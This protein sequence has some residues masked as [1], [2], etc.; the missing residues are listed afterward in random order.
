MA[1]S[2]I[3]SV[4]I[5][6]NS[7]DAVKAFQKATSKAA[8]FGSFMGGAA[9][10]GVT[11][12]WDKVSSFGSA[13]MNMSDSTD[14]FVSTMNFAGIDTSNV[15]KASKAARDYADR[16]VYDLSTIQNTTAQ[17]AAN[18]IG[19]Y[20]GLTEAAGNLNAV[21]GGNADTF[22]SVA[23][24]LT[25]TAGAGKLTTENWNQMADAIPGA[26]GKLQKAMKANGAYTGNFRDAMEK[27]EISAAEF[28]Q[29]I[30]Q[31]GMSDVAKEAASSTKTMEGA[32]GN[33]EAAITGGLTDAFD[34]IKPAVTGALTEA[35]NQISQFSQNATN[36]LQQFIQGISDTGALQAFSDMVS[37]IGNALSALGGAF[38]SIATT[39]APGLQGLSDAGGIGTTVGEAFNDAAGIIQ[40]LADKLTQFG[41][42]VSANAEPISGALIAIGGGFA[43]FKVAGV[44]SAVVSALQGFN[45][46]AEAAS[47]G[48]W[49][50]NAA[51]NANPIMIVVTA[52]GALVSALA[53]FFTQTETG[54]QI[55]S[56]FT[57]F[58]G[59]CVNNIIAFFQSLPGR[60]GAFFQS[61]A[62]GA[63]NTW[64]SVVDWFKGLPGRIL[65]AIGN[66]GNLLADAGKSIIDGFLKGLKSAWNKVTGWIGG[67]GD[68]I[69]AH[70]GPISYDRRLLVP[71][72]NAI[73]TGFAQGLQSGF[74]ST[75]RGTIGTVNRR[76]ASTSLAIGMAGVSGSTVVNKYEITVSG[77]VT[78]PD[79]TAKQIIRLIER[80]EKSRR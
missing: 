61:A 9:L 34:L 63:R 39:I 77:I 46:A 29:A 32:L 41:D 3:M 43:A 13:V 5:T 80:R 42:W 59:N 50:L 72:G 26:S 74:D 76:L 70:K 45:L 64:N 28:N 11:A 20:T 19:D 60:I 17:L 69:K 78:D 2:A 12:L 75:V 55:W 37:S 21:A 47:I 6:G 35:G 16:T 53:W 52:I 38:A 8:A 15:E 79:A 66:V 67:I 25:Q 4:R 65:D 40:A 18:G 44:I 30:M 1:H 31:L 51:M 14:K 54:R 24:V 33:L 49:A 10:K 36:G 7:D 71:A 48:Q 73:M 57:A 58:L 22:R 23:M 62:D 68:W 27:G 56:R